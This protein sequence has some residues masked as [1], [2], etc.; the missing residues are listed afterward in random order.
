[1]VPGLYGEE[2]DS[3]LD[4]FGIVLRG[5]DEPELTKENMGVFEG[6]TLGGQRGGQPPP[7]HLM[8]RWAADFWACP[9]FQ[10]AFSHAPP[11]D[12]C[13]LPPAMVD[14]ALARAR[15]DGY[16]EWRPRPTSTYDEY[17]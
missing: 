15:A 11:D 3:W 13:T 9:D 10:N 1:L 17:G 7:G 5:T 4:L 2:V 14:Y 6:V 12:R 8:R 16:F